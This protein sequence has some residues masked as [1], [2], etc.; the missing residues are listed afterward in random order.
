MTATIYLDYAASTPV[1]RE[2]VAAITRVLG[3]PVLAAN[4]A[5][6]TH[7]PG[8]Q[9]A[10]V[11]E[12]ARA[13]VAAL[14]NADPDEVIFTSGAT[15][16]DN[17]A[18]IGT[19]RF[20]KSRGRHL[21]TALTEHKAVLES[22]RHL[23]GEGWR[24]TWLRPGTDG[25]IA[26]A[27]V[28]AALEPDTVL[29]SL[30]HANNETGDVTDVAAIGAICRQGGAL[31]HVDAAQSAGR[32]PIDVRAMQI[33]LLSL[34]AHKLYGPK[35]IGALFIDRERVRRV[36]PLLFGGGQE[37][38]MRPG[39]LPTHQIVGMGEAFRIAATRIGEDRLHVM[40]LRDR[41]WSRLQAIPGV[42]LNGHAGQGT[43][44]TT[45]HILN[46]SVAGVE[47]E[48]L[49][50]ALEE[51]AVASGSACTSLTDEPS[52]VLRVLGRSPALA[53][54]SVRFSFGRPTTDREVDRAADVFNRAVTELRE[55]APGS[56]P[57]FTQDGEPAGTLLARGEAGSEEAGTRVVFAARVRE[58]RVASLEARVFGCPHTRAAC[59]RAVQLLTGAAVAELGR[60]E[61]RLLGAD[62]GIPPEKAGRLLVIQDALRN[63][64]A[65]WDNAQLK[66]AP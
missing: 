61:P 32:L 38:G 29:V 10:A 13:S 6:G 44:Q 41:L 59:D 60:L 62:L 56:G 45:G 22:C 46:V 24:V 31:L 18:I 33:D 27:A 42:L 30:M 7:A 35:G 23:A 65:D 4:P 28:A 63:C 14:I 57:P 12:R 51:L 54:S 5:A 58:G 43:S 40:R 50:A 21:V 1:A 25:L 26:P 3:E 53:R 48:S 11:V 8:R 15:E 9:A 19:A 37:R 55:R 66:P 47:G 52:Y 34:S 39:T 64:L 49:H 17:L 2:V 16:A 20:R 36:E